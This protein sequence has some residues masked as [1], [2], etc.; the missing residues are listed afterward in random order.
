V[1]LI[2]QP[3]AAAE[4]VEAGVMDKTAFI[5]KIGGY[6]K[7][8]RDT[9]VK[10]LALAAGATGR[11]YDAAGIL[12][13][14]NL[15]AD[16]VVA[17]ILVSCDT[18]PHAGGKLLKPSEVAEAAAHKNA[19]LANRPPLRE[20]VAA[21]ELCQSPKRTGCCTT[22]KQQAAMLKPSETAEAAAAHKNAAL[23]NCLPL[24]ESVAA[25]ELCQ[26]A[27]RT[28]CC[29]IKKQ[30]A[31]M[32]E[33]P[34][35]AEAAAAHKNAALANRPPL[36]ESVAAPELCQPP[37]R[38]GCCTIKKQQAAML[39][40][41]ETAEAAAAEDSFGGTIGLL[42]EGVARLEDI[43][44][45]GA[46]PADAE[47]IR[48]MLFA[49][50]KD[51]RVIFIKLACVLSGLRAA[52]APPDPLTAD[53]AATP[54]SKEARKL[55]ARDC[56]EIYAPLAD[57]LGISW[58]KAEL[59]DLALKA[60]NPK[61]YQQIKQIV[62]KKRDARA[63]FLHSVREKI[64]AEAASLG[65]A[66]EVSSR[67]KHFYSIYEK[68]RKRGKAEEEVFDLFGIRLF[69]DTVE[70]C[71]NLLG[72]VHRLWKPLA[73]RF[74]D[75]IAMPKANGYQSLHTTVM[76]EGGEPLEVQIRT[77]EMHHVA[78]YGVASHWL[79]KNGAA[80]D[81]VR[82]LDIAIVS[83]LREWNESGN[84][85]SEAFLADIKREIL[86]DS[87]YVFTP[88]GAV[89]ELPAGATAIDFA[90]AIHSAIGDRCAAAKADGA[91]IPLSA[92]LQTT[93]VVE[94]LTSP[95]ARPHLNW[96][97]IAK[98]AKA[99]SRIRSWLQQYDAVIIEKNVV[100]KKKD[101]APPREPDTREE[102]HDAR[103]AGRRE[104]PLEWVMPAPDDA[105]VLQVRVEDEENLMIRFARC[106]RPIT[107]DSIIGYVSRGKGII[108][109]RRNCR[110]LAGI[111]DF[112]ERRIECEW[113]WQDAKAV[114]RFRA[115]YEAQ[116]D[117]FSEIEGA[118]KNHQGHLVDG[119]LE[120]T[121]H[122]RKTGFFTIQV[123]HPGDVRKIM[124]SIRA[125]PSV[126]SITLL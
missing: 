29:T 32:L 97:G 111:A 71:Y 94:I 123:S 31:A 88:K 63:A 4:A 90:Y 112:A 101:A 60:V 122:G 38:T 70:T 39:E 96:L 25:P 40:P 89:I 46:A 119:R 18:P 10:A 64:E 54:P 75:Y 121:A 53:A 44:A 110:N 11:A 87:I 82:P 28:G 67:A 27:K 47:K 5:A 69:C 91:I 7:R 124:K 30:Q 37:K 118:V 24:R 41:S 105:G 19:A 80:R 83:R 99:R 16:T 1:K 76:A 8:D 100:A 43:P 74:K 77:R 45:H 65:I 120:Q 34:E 106:C 72:M 84:A 102:P 126:F 57:R 98:T 59:E 125:I 104:R 3:E 92:E 85:G 42:V 117:I 113:E 58:I 79:Y 6:A 14:L 103:V 66:I 35:T 107:G 48:K 114:R 62:A 115:E 51:I 108:I 55:M 116:A 17:A 81:I 15:D 2:K 21:P 22:L 86:R 9:I 13:D 52:S 26:S 20:S 93:Q 50:A 36:R 78:E 23:A 33:Q 109:H 73:G 12:V 61:A 68:M 95:N 49:M 56:L